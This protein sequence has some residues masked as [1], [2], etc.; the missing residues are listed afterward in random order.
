MPKQISGVIKLKKTPSHFFID[1]NFSLKVISTNFFAKSSKTE[2]W[3]LI[4]SKSFSGVLEQSS[5]F[6]ISLNCGYSRKSWISFEYINFF[7]SS[8]VN[9]LGSSSSGAPIGVIS[10]LLGTRTCKY[11]LFLVYGKNNIMYKQFYLDFY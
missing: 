11:F 6:M 10:F 4:K 7:R 9:L 8:G 3:D 1:S 2:S 5:F